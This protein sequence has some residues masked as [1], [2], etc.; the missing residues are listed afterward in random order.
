MAVIG[1]S[2]ID[3]EEKTD[4]NTNVGKQADARWVAL[5][6]G[7]KVLQMPRAEP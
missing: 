3:S 7:E 1:R 6:R 2:I 4:E 5:P